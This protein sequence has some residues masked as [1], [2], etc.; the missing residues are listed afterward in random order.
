MQ[1]IINYCKIPSK[2]LFAENTD[3]RRII[4]VNIRASVLF[5][6]TKKARKE[7]QDPHLQS[8]NKYYEETEGLLYMD[9]I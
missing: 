1:R 4:L 8:K 5:H 7:S 9:L 3:K 6:K 2:K